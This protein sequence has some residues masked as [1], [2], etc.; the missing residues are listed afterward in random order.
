MDLKYNKNGKFSIIQFTD[1]H[2]GSYPFSE[3]DE[4]TLSLIDKSIVQ[5]SPDLIVFT[6]DTIWSLEKY[7]AN[8]PKESFIEF[9]N[10]VNKHDVAVALTFGNHE[11]EDKVTREDLR[12]IFNSQIT[13]LATQHHNFVINDRE[14]YVLELYDSEDKEIKNVFYIIDSGDYPSIPVGI[15]DWVQPEQVDWFREI[16]AKYRKGDGVKR[17][18]VFQH[19]P[20]PEYWFASQNIV[21]GNFNEDF[22]VN[23]DSFNI[24]NGVCSPMINSGLFASMLM[25]RETWGMFVGHDHDNN[26]D[27][28]LH[29][30]HLVYGQSS[31]FNSYGKEEKGIRVI[32]LE[33]KTNSIKTYRILEK[34]L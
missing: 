33:E 28:I 7:G 27:G 24:K 8:N 25:D 17:N 19:I 30:I 20:L 31:G 34:D 1:V 4:K 3:K 12:N 2:L 18:L 6:G 11:T 14:S 23:L 10:R 29:D 32:E 15:Y 16:S 22:E 9:I 21:E 13:N 5:V 26:Y